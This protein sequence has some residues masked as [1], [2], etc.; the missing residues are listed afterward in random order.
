MHGGNF[1]A[2]PI[3][4]SSQNCLQLGQPIIGS[5]NELLGA[6]AALFDL[7]FMSVALLFVGCLERETPPCYGVAESSHLLEPWI[8]P[9]LASLQYNRKIR[10]NPGNCSRTLRTS[11]KEC[12]RIAEMVSLP[13]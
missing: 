6:K 10:L 4:E 13:L 1:Q 12:N 8:P 2:A 3:S 9:M 11:L 5:F 7:S